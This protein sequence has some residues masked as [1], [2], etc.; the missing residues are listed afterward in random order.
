MFKKLV[1]I[2]TIFFPSICLAKYAYITTNS[3]SK[4]IFYSGYEPILYP[5]QHEFLGYD[6][7]CE[8]LEY[9]SFISVKYDLLNAFEFNQD[10]KAIYLKEDEYGFDYFLKLKKSF[11]WKPFLNRE[12]SAFDSMY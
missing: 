5:F 7:F 2:I 9:G 3:G 8:L 4:I 12:I 1:L 11:L 10:I 6:D